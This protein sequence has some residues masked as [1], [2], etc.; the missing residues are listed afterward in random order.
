MHQEQNTRTYADGAEA[1]FTCKSASR[2][3]E[4]VARCVSLACQ[5]RAWQ[6]DTYGDDRFRALGT[7]TLGESFTAPPSETSFPFGNQRIGLLLK[8]MMEY[9]S[10]ALSVERT[11]DG[12]HRAGFNPW[13]R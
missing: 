11:L 3:V 13:G 1:A 7:G 12:L 10:H 9:W 4:R 2:R 6:L 8:V 5:S